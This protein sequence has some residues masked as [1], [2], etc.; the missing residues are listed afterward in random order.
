MDLFLGCY[1]EEFVMDVKNNSK[2]RKKIPALFLCAGLFL[3][4]CLNPIGFL[5]DLMA[6][7]GLD[8]STDKPGTISDPDNP[9]I[10]PGANSGVIVFKNLSGGVKAIHADFHITGTDNR[11][12]KVDYII[13]LESGQERSL[14]LNPSGPA[15]A[16]QPYNIAITWQGG[17]KNIG[18]FLMAGRAEYV[19]F[20][21]NKNTTNYDASGESDEVYGNIDLNN[22]LDIENDRENNDDDSQNKPKEGDVSRDDN[23]RYKLPP[24]MR[25]NYGIVLVHNISGSMPL[26]KLVF[27]HTVSGVHWEMNPGPDSGNLK[28]IILRPGLWNVRSIWIDPNDPGCADGVIKDFTVVKAGNLNKLNHLYFYKGLDGKWH[29]TAEENN[30]LW[31]PQP[32][33]TD[34]HAGG[35]TGGGPGTAEGDSPGALTDG[36]RNTLGLMILKNLSRD[37]ALTGAS[38]VKQSGA[39]TWSMNPGPGVNDQKSILLSPGDWTVTASY[40]KPTVTTPGKTVTIIPGQVSYMY[41]YKTNTGDYALSPDWPPNPNDAAKDNTNPNSIIGD[42]E[43]WLNV[44][45]KSSTS[46]ID[47]VQYNNAGIWIDIAIPGPTGTIAPQDESD[48]DLAVPKGAWSFRFKVVTKQTYSRAVSRTILAGQTVNITYTD[49]L[50][51]DDPPNGFG[52][53][54][55]VNDSSSSVYRVTHANLTKGGPETQVNLNIPQ[56]QYQSIVLEAPSGTGARYTYTVKCYISSGGAV[57][58]VQEQVNIENQ[59]ISTITITNDMTAVTELGNDGKGHIR[60]YNNY[61][62]YAVRNA[63]KT[64]RPTLPV[65]FFK[66]GLRGIDAN[67]KGHD[68]VDGGTIPDDKLAAGHL[69]LR[70]GSFTQLDVDHEGLYELWILW[71]NTIADDSK[72]LYLVNYGTYSISKN[73]LRDIHVDFYSLNT[74]ES[75]AVTMRITHVGYPAAAGIAQV[76]IWYAG[77]DPHYGVPGKGRIPA[78]SNGPTNDTYIVYKN[79]DILYAGDYREWKLVPG[80][81]YWA[82]VHWPLWNNWVGTGGFNQDFTLVELA[83]NATTGN[84]QFV[85]DDHNDQLK[86]FSDQAAGIKINTISAAATLMYR[87]A[88]AAPANRR[89]PHNYYGLKSVT[90]NEHNNYIEGIDITPYEGTFPVVFAENQFFLATIHWFKRTGIIS[91]SNVGWGPVELAHT[92]TWENNNVAYT[93]KFAATNTTTISDPAGWYYA[94]VI[95]SPKQGYDVSSI[96]ANS[97]TGHFFEYDDYDLANNGPDPIGLAV[98]AD[99]SNITGNR[100]AGK[101]YH[102]GA[103]NNSGMS[104]IGVSGNQIKVRLWFREVQPYPNPSGVSKPA[105]Y[106]QHP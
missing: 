9:V 85:F 16:P 94:E 79:N 49:A 48:P 43:G 69:N 41:F 40:N 72:S 81:K 103:G 13:S 89:A 38:L 92:G 54:K 76:Q 58:Y 18:K 95:L 31:N 99:N 7:L 22:Y 24:T 25:E 57:R 5:P 27:D 87:P 83:A 91:T 73:T 29:L 86:F 65:K 78:H 62:N 37:H 15:S 44:L 84:L 23:P 70:T 36:N 33:A 51:S 63:A 61:D 105:G 80:K 26:L 6:S 45:N 39:I 32:D 93:E 19:Y 55:V 96:P 34:Y 10:Y 3:S 42:N 28:S 11:D 59:K 101:I 98:G 66:V 82:R 106:P 17:Q 20:Y 2:N 90:R 64:L 56:G 21:F 67:T 74:A 68:V 8:I 1:Y 52:T 77:D 60:V 53:L 97:G 14:V 71:G 75:S 30:S 88:A 47:R 46:I 35:H 100:N 50:D 102:G 104:S 12:A 4:S